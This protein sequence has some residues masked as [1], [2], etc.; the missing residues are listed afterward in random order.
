VDNS[1]VSR[2]AA[3]APIAT[4]WELAWQDDRLTCAVY[5]REGGLQLRLESR[6]ATI[7]SE[8]FDL[9]PR[10]LAR[11]KALRNSLKR[12]GWHDLHE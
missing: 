3:D 2:K 12:R 1:G 11:S 4:L 8:P 9:Q 6:N 5:K 10:M 7:L